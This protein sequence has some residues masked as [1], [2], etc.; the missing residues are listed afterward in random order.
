MEMVLVMNVTINACPVQKSLIVQHA[1][2]QIDFQSLLV[3]VLQGFMMIILMQIV[4][5]VIIN[6]KAVQE[7]LLPASYAL[8]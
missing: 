5:L 3:N 4:Q 2:E 6:A 8:T 1:K 7:M